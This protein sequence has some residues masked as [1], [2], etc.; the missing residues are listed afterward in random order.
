[1]S[2]GER[3]LWWVQYGRDGKPIRRMYREQAPQGDDP[4][5]EAPPMIGLFDLP[6]K[7]RG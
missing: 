2:R 6:S 5:P 7:P 4:A 1:M 3:I